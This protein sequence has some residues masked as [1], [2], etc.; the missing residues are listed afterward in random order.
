MPSHHLSGAA[1][2]KTRRERWAPWCVLAI[3]LAVAWP[4]IQAGWTGFDESFYSR[5]NLYLLSLAPDNL[6]RLLTLPGSGYQFQPTVYLSHALDYGLLGDDVHWLDSRDALGAPVVEPEVQWFHAVSVL[7]YGWVCFWVATL[8]SE[9]SR[10]LGL[11]SRE[12][13]V[14]AFVAGGLFALHPVHVENYAWL[15]DRKDLLASG[16]AL[17][18]YAVARRARRAESSP[19]WRGVVGSLALFVLAMGAKVSVMLLG[20]LLALDVALFAGGTFRR[21]VAQGALA[22]APLLLLGAG[23]SL[24]WYWLQLQYQLPLA[25][26]TT[27]FDGSRILYVLRC[28]G[29]Y[30]SLLFW[31]A[32]LS[33]HYYPQHTGAQLSLRLA[34]L[35]PALATLAVLAR[36]LPKLRSALILGGGWFF[37]TL[38]PF[39]NVVWLGYVNDRY[40]LFPSV[41]VALLLGPLCAVALSRHPRL[42]T[43]VLVAV[44]A[45]LGI[46]S[47]QRIPAWRSTETLWESALKVDPEQPYALGQLAAMDLRNGHHESARERVERAR[48]ISPHSG[49][50]VRIHVASLRALG[51]EQAALE[52]LEAEHASGDAAQVDLSRAMTALQNGGLTRARVLLEGLEAARDP[53]IQLAWGHLLLAEGQSNRALARFEEVL[54]ATGRPDAAFYASHAARAAG[55]TDRALE[56]LRLLER[57][58]WNRHTDLLAG[59][60]AL[61]RGDPATA[62]PSLL[63]VAAD[64]PEDAPALRELA[65]ALG[66]AGAA[67]EALGVLLRAHAEGHTDALTLYDIARTKA[68]LGD[69]AGA[70][71]FLNQAVAKD[72]A[73]A[74]R[75]ED[76]PVF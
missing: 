13:G 75:A 33:V 6:L 18:A 17:W 57:K 67:G 26:E 2:R 14:A 45:L 4:S 23:L 32:D 12:C 29:H 72:P 10:D 15:G 76:D 63:A 8:V 53:S 47:G 9:L 49:A 51:E 20:G 66:R 41:G 40:L 38:L 71:S 73:L 60:L 61:D 52:L 68:Y 16:F 70:R 35:I 30:I 36:R 1:P 55:R 56:H 42:T 39:V 19:R 62:L 24:G 22:G 65:A 58:G 27:A 59:L 69:T 7:L 25:R 21:R 46:R 50:L 64:P 28:Y 43:C 54:H 31:P 34:P 3:A 48:Q 44:S 11:S 37:L 74:A 5:D